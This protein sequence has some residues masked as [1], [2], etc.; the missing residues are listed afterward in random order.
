MIT[1]PPL[2]SYQVSPDKFLASDNDGLRSLSVIEDKAGVNTSNILRLVRTPEGDGVAA[3]RH[4]RAVDMWRTNRKTTGLCYVDGRANADFVVVLRRGG[5][6]WLICVKE[7]ADR[8]TLGTQFATYSFVTSVLALYPGES[9]QITLPALKSLFTIPSKEQSEN[10]F[11]V[12]IAEDL[13]ILLVR[14]DMN[15]LKLV[16]QEMLPLSDTPKKILPVD[17]MAWGSGHTW[18]DH[19]VLLSISSS[20]DLTF[21]TLEPK[22]TSWQGQS[23]NPYNGPI[24]IRE[25]WKCTGSVKTGR[26]NFVKARCSSAKKTSLSKPRDFTPIGFD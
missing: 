13:S 23:S 7:L 8:A 10:E 15:D 24:E 26:G 19:D 5:L 22:Q 16:S 6:R 3:V 21:W 2:G 17:P 12:G 25:T 1:S 14:A 9:S 4:G 20:G 18:L 11:I